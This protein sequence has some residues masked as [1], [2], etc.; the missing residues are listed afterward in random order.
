MNRTK[1]ML[2][3]AG[4]ALMTAG[5]FA[6][7][8]TVTLHR[9]QQ[10]YPWNGLVDIDYTVENVGNPEDYYVKF[11]VTTN[12]AATGILARSFLNDATLAMASNGSFRVTWDTKADLAILFSK[13]VSVRADLVFDPGCKGNRSPYAV[14]FVVID[15]TEGASATSYP[16][17]YE[18][19]YD[20]EVA[21]TNFNTAIYKTDKLVMRRI[22]KTIFT[23][24]APTTQ[25]GYRCGNNNAYNHET[26]HEVTLT[27][28]YDIGIFEITQKQWIN[29]MGS[30]PSGGAQSA[31]GDDIA[32]A[33]ITYELV[34]GSV[35]GC[36]VALLPQGKVDPTSFLGKLRERTGLDTLD[37]PTEAQWENA[38]RAG[39]TTS[40]Y[41][42]DVALTDD[43]TLGKYCWYSI[44]NN[45]SGENAQGKMHGVGQK[46][47]NAWG[48][49]D[50]LGNV[51]EWC[52][53]RVTAAPN[54]DWGT[55]PVTDPLR[56]VNGTVVLRGGCWYN[57]SMRLRSAARSGNLTVSAPDKGRGFRL[58]RTLP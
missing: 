23:M 10:R 7:E 21:K 29:V 8:P 32:C 34:R 12:G 53:D 11:T 22:H 28:D 5:A 38:C 44:N 43:A 16:V 13:D 2:A 58:S 52:R 3:L 15:L 51:W 50:M 48:L 46:L 17:A 24:G 39:T 40:T 57:D 30:L 35:D 18:G 4:A 1:T 9:F 26:L 49:Y 37:L 14:E 20:K 56:A 27:K 54:D 47:P 19:I 55:A 45:G 6:D 36:N 33:W 42:G 41:F 25:P 31:K